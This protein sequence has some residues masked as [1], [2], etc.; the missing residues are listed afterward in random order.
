MRAPSRAASLTVVLALGAAAT[1]AAQAPAPTVPVPAKPTP[2]ELTLDWQAPATCPAPAD[3]EAQ[4][5]RLLGGAA[6]V[7]TG[8]HVTAT[9][10]VHVASP[11]RWILEL[12][13]TLDGAGGKRSLSGDS[14]ASVAS[15]A[16]LILALMI[17]PA[18]A[19]RLGADE[20]PPPPPKP[21]PVAIVAPPPAP[22]PP[23]FQLQP[24]VRLFL[25]GVFF[26]LPEPTLAAGLAVGVRHRHL[27]VELTGLATAE[28]RGESAAV[29]G[30]GGDF[31]LLAGGARAC[32]VLGE[33]VLYQ[34]C[35]GGELERLSGDGVALAPPAKGAP[36]A[37]M[38]AGTGAALVSIPLGARLALTVEVGV[39][40]RPY[41]PTFAVD[42]T[43]A[44]TDDVMTP[45]FRVPA[46]SASGAAG[47]SLNL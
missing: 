35:L 10:A 34:L 30:S 23:S 8:K 24:S 21:A 6:R 26:L 41:R 2:P 1:A 33:R 29:A 20:P 38:L 44:V 47:L 28:R 13:T 9:A 18:A 5:A 19:E 36:R 46:F 3:V 14:C 7:P 12:T 4:F 15:A 27:G 43:P 31:R 42:M 39:A 17:D 45:V 11:G 16:A 22:E 40:A 25:G 32:G 37:T